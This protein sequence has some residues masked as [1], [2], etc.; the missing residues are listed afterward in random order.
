MQGSGTDL[1]SSGGSGSFHVP[2]DRDRQDVDR[3]SGTRTTRV[4]ENLMRKDGEESFLERR[5]AK[6]RDEIAL[7]RGETRKDSRDAWGS[8]IAAESSRYSDAWGHQSGSSTISNVET[9][10]GEMT[11]GRVETRERELRFKEERL[12]DGRD[13]SITIHRHEREEFSRNRDRMEELRK[14]AKRDDLREQ[15]RLRDKA[16]QREEDARREEVR[17]RDEERRRE[18]EKRREDERRK[19]EE[20]RKVEQKRKEEEKRKA[21]EKRKKEEQHLEEERKQ[22]EAEIASLQV[23]EKQEAAKIAELLNKLE[24][25]KSSR[26]AR[27]VKWKEEE[28][29]AKKEKAK[30]MER[31]IK[32]EEEEAKRKQE[33]EETQAKLDAEFAAK[34]EQVA[35]QWEKFLKETGE[36]NAMEVALDDKKSADSNKTV[37][38][39]EKKLHGTSAQIS[40][41]RKIPESTQKKLLSPTPTKVKTAE[42]SSKP[43]SVVPS[44]SV[45]G[46]AG[47]QSMPLEESTSG[48]ED[49]KGLKGTRKIIKVKKRVKVRKESEEGSAR[50]SGSDKIHGEKME[51]SKARVGTNIF[52]DPLSSKMDVIAASLS[53]FAKAAKEKRQNQQAATAVADEVAETDFFIDASGSG[54]PFMEEQLEASRRQEEEGLN[55]SKK[56]IHIPGLDFKDDSSSHSRKRS[57]SQNFPQP[58]M[59]KMKQMGGGVGTVENEGRSCVG[60]T[61]SAPPIRNNETS[62]D[63]G[64]LSRGSQ[65]QPPSNTG[66]GVGGDERRYS[67]GDTRR[68][69]HDDTV[70]RQS[71]EKNRGRGRGKAWS[72]GVH[73]HD[74]VLPPPKWTPEQFQ[75]ESTGR[76]RQ[77]TFGGRGFKNQS[78][79]SERWFGG[80]DQTGG[81]GGNY[82]ELQW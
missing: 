17:R 21:E 3:Y 61:G 2:P 12:G 73:S 71:L 35:Q 49:E 43:V 57:A 23:A 40:R 54:D 77:Q 55:E 7:L 27:K 75:H 9:L 48:V 19:K 66:K 29:E 52:K 79:N 10:L 67:H 6:L 70:Q 51:Q 38:P 14:E 78:P 74:G 45:L 76:G 42:T 47:P 20:R 34:Q 82:L 32:E 72:A 63:R 39:Q 1:S 81:D 31:A 5:E 69:G 26:L 50:S 53:E 46:N 68:Q 15:K 80:R 8:E 4:S 25:L 11:R 33:V 24:E 37:K 62:N 18:E 13:L 56:Q 58:S 65:G 30:Q 36:S 44:R 60:D 59:T 16:R 64:V 22:R 41:S 28:E